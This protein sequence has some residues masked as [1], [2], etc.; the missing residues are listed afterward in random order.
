MKT[1][2]DLFLC[3]EEVE[4]DNYL[5]ELNLI[6]ATHPVGDAVRKKTKICS[7]CIYIGSIIGEEYL[8]NMLFKKFGITDLSEKPGLPKGPYYVIDKSIYNEIA[9]MDKEKLG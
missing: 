3:E 8:K 2:L 4:G 9:G 5:N 7:P 1:T 6:V